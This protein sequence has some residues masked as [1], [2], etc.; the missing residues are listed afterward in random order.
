MM[1][2]MLECISFNN[3]HMHAGIIHHSLAN[4]QRSDQSFTNLESQMGSIETKSTGSP[5]LFSLSCHA[6]LAIF[7][8]AIGRFFTG[9]FFN[10]DC[11]ISQLW[12]ILGHTG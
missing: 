3:I 5:C 10:S 7:I 9:Y 1:F 6:R 11:P 4:S 12:A 8:F 2:F